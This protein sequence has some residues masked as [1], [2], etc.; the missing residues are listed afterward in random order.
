M[1]D[2]IYGFPKVKVR[3]P[4]RKYRV[5]RRCLVR[6]RLVV[7]E[8]CLGLSAPNPQIITNSVPL[9]WRLQQVSACTVCV[10]VV[11]TGLSQHQCVVLHRERLHLASIGPGAE[12][13]GVRLE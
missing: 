1:S 7:G 8:V 10:N 3:Q 2:S 5:A 11:L 4:R 13:R 9:Q 12:A 6:L